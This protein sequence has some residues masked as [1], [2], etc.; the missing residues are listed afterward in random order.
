MQH[1]AERRYRVD[2]EVVG[3]YRRAMDAARASAPANYDLLRPDWTLRFTVSLLAIALTWHGDLAEA[4]Q[5]HEEAMAMGERQGSPILRGEALTGLAVI[6]MRRGEIEVVREL[7][8]RA[9]AE[10]APGG[11][12]NHVAVATALLA[13]AAWR[14]HRVQEALALGTEALEAWEPHPYVYPYNLALWPLAG[15]YLDTGKVEEAVGAAR[16][17]LEPSLARLPDELEAAV[18][19][20]CQAWD[21]AEPE[22][23]GRLLADAVQLACDLGYA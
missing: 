14:D 3:E 10:V 1:L 13:W 11:H 16:R 7:A 19:A 21:R 4:R 23:A 12:P 2:E 5:L 8:P 18:H 6:A 17:L 9:R 15:A 22:L 20:A